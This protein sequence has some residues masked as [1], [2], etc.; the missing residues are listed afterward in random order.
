MTLKPM[1][2]YFIVKIDKEKQKARKEKI[3][4]IYVHTSH[5]FMQR[6]LQCGEIIAI[7]WLAHKNFPDA[8]IGNTLLFHHFVEGGSGSDKSNLIYEDKTHN[9]YNVTASQFNG[10][11]NESYGIW[12]GSEIIPHPEFVFIEPEIK[13]KEIAVDDFIEQNT[14]KVGSLILF[15]DWEETR[16]AKELK[17]ATITEEIK[18]MSKGKHLS[19]S[20]KMGLQEKQLEAEK[21]TASLNKQQYLPYKI[22]WINKKTIGFL[23]TDTGLKNKVFSLSVAAQTEMEFLGKVYLIVNSKYCVALSA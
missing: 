23:Q 20:T 15:N 17:A 22:A 13:S 2:P 11:R 1:P 14:K 18:S 21:I 10:S 7:G 6:N 4:S 8:E 12:N 9:Y 5:A 19:D 16:E 3:G